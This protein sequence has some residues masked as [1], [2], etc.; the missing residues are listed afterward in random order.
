MKLKP[1]RMIK[2]ISIPVLPLLFCSLVSAQQTSGPAKLPEAVY[3]RAHN[4]DVQH[5]EIDLQV[6][7]KK[8]RADGSTSV[9]FTL[10]NPADSIILD[11][12]QLTV[13]AVELE[14]GTALQ[15]TNDTNEST[16]ALHIRLGRVVQPAEKVTVKIKYHTNYVN[17]TDPNNTWGSTGK[18]LR[19]FE[20]TATEP[21]RRAQVWTAGEPEGNRFWF[22]CYDAP[23][24]LYTSELRITIEKPLT[25]IANGLLAEIKELPGGLR[26]FHWKDNTPHACHRN[27]FVAGEYVD[28]PQTVNGI[29]LHSFGYPDEREATA[30]STVRLGD[31]MR[32][33]SE[34]TGVAYPYPEYTQV[35]VQELPAWNGNS[36]M[37][38][39]TENMIDDYGTHA[40]YFYL[41]DLTEAEALAQQWFGNYVTAADWSECWLDKSFA[42]YFNELYHEQKNGR[43]EFL[44]YQHAYDLNSM[45]LGDWYAGIRQPVVTKN[46][47]GAEAMA[48]SNYPYFRGAL[49]LHMLRNEL[50]ET[51]WWKAVRLYL[52]NN[53]GKTVTTEDFR[54]AIETATGQPMDWFFNQWVYGMGH[55]V[56]EVTKSYDAVK[57]QLTLRVKQTQ[58][59]D[60]T[61]AY[62]QVEF[63]SGKMDIGIDGRIEQ[64]QLLSQAE[65]VFVFTVTE[66][67]KLVAFDYEGTWI[68]EV[69]FE[70]TT[71]ELLYQARNDRDILGRTAAVNA[72]AAIAKAEKTLPEEKEKIG[73]TLREIVGG[74]YWWRFRFNT[75][76]AL[77]GIMAPAWDAKSVLRDEITIAMLEKMIATEKAWMKTAAISFLGMTRDPRFASVYI[78]A[79][80]DPSDRVV[81]A[82]AIALGRSKSPE[83]FAALV[84]L[85]DKPSWKNQSLI[86]TL[87]GLKELGDPRGFDVAYK[88][89]A[90][91]TS[92]RWTLATPVW[93]FRLAAAQTIASLGKSDK[94]YGLVR[95]RFYRAMSDNDINS[96]FSNVQLIVTLADPRGKEIFQPL[97]EKFKADANAMRAVLQYETQLND[98]VKK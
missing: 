18:G 71:D 78:S 32:Y 41:W 77:Q 25:V 12:G 13:Q 81:N 55:P 37:S 89:L 67:P 3:A 46:H 94:A 2:Q 60:S 93:D 24:D 50:G 64:V 63:F 75:L 16:G 19:F 21:K 92:P 4:T 15:F 79:F 57:K 66:N 61:S 14:N 1:G 9:S 97:K 58:Q 54:K 20:P 34:V 76:Q 40:D 85:K 96:M 69:T 95:K 80:A 62:P 26:M 90:D 30:A 65:N 28:V 74:N 22:P 23:N 17:E 45:Y 48:G 39:I 47:N 43:D 31:M 56:F 51:N 88:A 29:T 87:Y 5:I 11:A 68:K 91:L 33:F 73:A 7:R 36:T 83:A 84:K 82:A 6:D 72:L 35:F 59:R 70:K 10:F 8:H 49:V 38:V 42:H 86:S 27:A 53:K 98:A 52:Q 44:V